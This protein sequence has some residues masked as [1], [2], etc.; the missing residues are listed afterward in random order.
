MCPETSAAPTVGRDSELAQL[1]SALDALA[2]GTPGCLALEGEPGIG[3]T[4]LLAE[5]RRRAEARDWLVLSGTAAEFE[6]DLPFSVWA[7]A[8]DAH[9]SGLGLDRTWGE[10]A[11]AELAQILPSLR[12][13]GR[14]A[15]E[16][17]AD[18]RYRAHR[19]ARRLLRSLAADGPLVLILDDL[20]WSDDAS[21]EL[22]TA[23]LRRGAD[24]PVLLALALRPGRVATRLAPAV[25]EPA[26]RR[27]ALAPLDGDEA[28]ALLAGLDAP[29]GDA[30]LRLA[31][32]NPFYL[33]QLARGNAAGRL[34]TGVAGN[35]ADRG[36]PGVP[37][38]VAAALADELAALSADERRL[39][40]AAAV[41]GEPF[42]PA[43]AAAVAE[44]PERE[45]LAALD[46]LLS[47]DLVRPTAVPPRLAFRHP[48][49]RRAVYEAT[50]YGWR[51]AGHARAA[52]T[53]AARGA[54]AAER[55]HHLEQSATQGDE[56]AIEVLLEAA[57]AT[58]P[59][60]PGAAA[61]WYEAVLRL[62]PSDD[63]PRH[64][65]VRAALARTLRSLGELERCRATLLE[66]LE[67][68]PADA[69]ARRVELTARCAA[70]EHWLGRH[71][72]AHR[73]LTLAWEDLED[74]ATLASVALQLELAVDGLYHLDFERTV[75][76]GR[77]AL[78]AARATGDRALIAAAAAALCL[79][80]VA[81]G[82]VGAARERHAE[83]VAQLDRLSDA[84]LAPR[85]ETLYYLG[86]A[87][88]YL[89]YYEAALTRVDRG[90]ALARATGDGR[91]LVPMTLVQGYTLEML[92]R[93]PAAIELC[94]AAVESTRLSGGPH[95]LAWA[96]H[97]LAHAHY[98][99]GD[100]EAAI[101]AAEESAQIGGRMAGA[102]M[103]ASGGG[104]GWVLAMALFEAGEVDRAHAMMH[105]LGGDDLAHK[106]P[107][108][109][110]F[111]WEVLALVELARGSSG[112]ADGYVRRAEAHAAALGLRL[113]AALARRARAAV[114]LAEGEAE[115]AARLASEAADLA[116]TVGARLPAAFSLALAGQALATLGDRTQAIAVLRNAETELD[117][118]GSLRG[119][120]AMRRE[121]RRLGARAEPR[122][123]AAGQDGGVGALTNREREIAELVTDRRTNR[124]I[125]AALFLSEKTIE[126]H[127]RNIFVKLGASSRVH[128][129]RAVERDRRG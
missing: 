75:E 106:I 76:I 110:C 93:M 109:R 55:A 92:G 44:L 62:L 70:V 1:E 43:L 47:L 125:A 25:R 119:R 27:I 48:L 15:G 64:V 29:D 129:A 85:L 127:L 26:A 16:P 59:R 23:L 73:R 66:T 71:D 65:E 7:D 46:G 30:I 87:E 10:D 97:E 28:A 11:V 84:E 78:D 101:V 2:A 89:E 114:L 21:I 117:A 56:A 115:Q 122:G 35:G 33:E 39:I 50:P 9:V 81:V 124:E 95:H 116:M 3:K 51:L 88:N 128:V 121:L 120:D 103:P 20:H 49:V 45:G 80:E 14:A 91:L 74:H 111:D 17:I 57:A 13:A 12:G 4:R 94:A 6:R 86:W 41:A 112:T 79:G 68:L 118:C 90:V 18:E 32:G 53:L 123:P 69:A 37:A 34:T 100:L 113:P 22:L 83:A 107:V 102:T 67:L 42:D 105:A 98:F 77:G 38:A 72:D 60:A 99:A 5:L 31:R 58:A 19:V 108:E 63:G 8:L 54:S 126:S 52:A 36:G 96:L 82:H 24:A 104:P 61:H 40:D